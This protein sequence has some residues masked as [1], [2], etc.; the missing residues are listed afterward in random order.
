MLDDLLE[1]LIAINDEKITKITPQNIK[2]GI[3]A[4]G[5]QGNVVELKGETKTV[6]PTTSQQTITP[7]SGKNG[8][9][10]VTVEAVTSSIDANITASNIKKNVEILGVT[11]TLEEGG[12][13]TI[14]DVGDNN[15]SVSGTT[16]IFGEPEYTEL[17]Y[18]QGT[19]TQYLTTNIT[20]SNS[21][22]V[23][24]DA[25]FTSVPLTEAYLFGGKTDSTQGSGNGR[26]AV[27]TEY[28]SGSPPPYRWYIGMGRPYAY[29]A[30]TDGTEHIF[31]IDF[32][33]NKYYIDGVQ[34]G[35]G[36]LTGESYPFYLFAI[37]T[38]TGAL[39]IAEAKVYSLKIQQNGETVLDLIP[40]QRISDDEVCMYDKVTETYFTNVGTG[41]FIAGPEKGGNE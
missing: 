31:K 29:N 39:G 6:T 23:E 5:V 20:V 7:S 11:G 14:L 1:K 35:T 13:E 30:V 41:S 37:N 12:G 8:I 40:V 10:E 33:E 32:V 36:D 18:I 27:G 28:I 38:S 16:L 21:T 17:E 15:V 24:L 25:G 22:I 2:S 34:G 4:F 3:T 19:G 9:T 26:C